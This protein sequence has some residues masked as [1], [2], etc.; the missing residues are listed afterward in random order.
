MKYNKE[1][2]K[3]ILK[4]IIIGLLIY[5]ILNNLIV[6]NTIFNNV[7]S[8]L[9]PFI[10]GVCIAF[11]LNLPM[12]FFE[13]LFSKSKKVK[14][15]PILT[16]FLAILMSIIVIILVLMI[17]LTIIIPQLINVV[18][19]LL[20]KAPYFTEQIKII[21]DETLENEDIKNII[22]EINVDTEQ[23]K[24]A[25]TEN[26]KTIILSSINIIS[27][28]IKGI[29]SF[30]IAIVFAFYLLLSKEKIKKW[31]KKILFAYIPKKKA[32]YILKIGRLSNNTFRKFILGQ[33]TEACILG[34][35]CF[36]GM[37]ILRIP[38]AGTI[39]VL[40]GITA[41]VPIVGA[42]IGVAIGILLIIT[43]DPIKAIIFIIFFLIL[44]QIE[45]NLI[46]PKVVGNSV[47]LPGILVLF[48][49]TIGGNLF[50]VVG[51]LIGLPIVSIIYTILKEDVNYRLSKRNIENNESM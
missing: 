49:V 4:I 13:S 32:Q 14:I 40:V 2:I 44:Q 51:M 30:V 46:Y 25:L 20:E 24:I 38:Y 1:D 27:K 34:A 45:G 33:L 3:S 26:I 35:L 6:I 47:G 29:T 7:F 19:L 15:K 48:A 41:L 37:L 28:T 9:F 12:K 50:G 17:L 8:V 42:F 43:V 10:L 18:T 23:I 16:R 11:I 31:V 22:N 5:W 21:A 39:G 36:L